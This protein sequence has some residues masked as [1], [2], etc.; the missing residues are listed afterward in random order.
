MSALVAE[1]LRVTRGKSTLLRQISLIFDATE[2]VAIIGPNGAGKST[3][4]KALAG[5]EAPTEGQVRLGRRNLANLTAAERAQTIGF[6][7]QHFEPHWDLGVAELLEI[8]AGR[9]RNLPVDALGQD[10]G[11]LR[12]GRPGTATLVDPVGRR[13]GEGSAGDGVGGRSTGAAGR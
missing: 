10:D 12:A 2:S 11:R 8:G 13:A 3:L 6:L 4:L 5:T 9:A 1:N 7:P